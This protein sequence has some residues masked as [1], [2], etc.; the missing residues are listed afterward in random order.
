MSWFEQK[1][2]TVLSII[3]G[4]LCVALL[5]VL[6]IRYRAAQAVPEDNE[7]IANAEIAETAQSAYTALRLRRD[8][9]ELEFALDA[10]GKWYWVSDPAFPLN[11]DS[12]SAISNMLADWEPQ[13][14][15]EFPEDLSVYEL[16][17]PPAV[18]TATTP[19][20]TEVILTM[21]KATD[22]GQS[23]YALLGEDEALYIISD[24]LYEAMQTPIYD[25]YDL[26]D[27]PKL[28]EQNLQTVI[29]Q[30]QKPSA[31][32]EALPDTVFLTALHPE[33]PESPTTWRS[34]NDIIT[35]LPALIA[36]MDDLENLEVDKCMDYRP[37]EE[38]IKLCG[39][40]YPVSTLTV[41]YTT[42]S[43]A[44]AN[45]SLS[46]GNISLDGDHRYVQL[47][48]DSTIFLM[49]SDLLD[50]LLRIAADGIYFE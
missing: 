9:M 32:P 41:H 31:D 16:S 7:Y 14:T 48:D 38:A 27:F 43:G 12:I 18:L 40:E 19:E 24:E 35:G 15:L 2:N 4:L 30:G 44:D 28:T 45:F 3:L 39:F 22:D 50:P 20:G 42:A 29:I 1:L 34:M 25:F 37:S 11:T 49:A 36:L 26:P 47:D 5:L 6:S 13:Q 23:R 17:D 8:K 33:N 46:V 10:N 21:G